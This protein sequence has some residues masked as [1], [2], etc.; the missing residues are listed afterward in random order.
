[1]TIQT[2]MDFFKRKSF[3]KNKEQ[4]LQYRNKGRSRYD[5]WKFPS[6]SVS[7]ALNKK[8]VISDLYNNTTNGWLIKGFMSTTEVEYALA[9]LK[10]LDIS[11]NGGFPKEA[12]HTNPRSFSMLADKETGVNEEL[13]DTY[14][15]DI[16]QYNA[17][18]Q[19]IFSFDYQERLLNFFS[20][21]EDNVD[22]QIPTIE[23]SGEKKQ[24]TT[25]TF[26]YCY[27][28]RGGMNTH[29][30]NMFPHIYP[31]FYSFLSKTMNIERQISYFVMLSKPEQGGDLVLY[32][33]LW[34][35]YVE[36]WDG[37]FTKANGEKALQADIDY[38]S[39]APEPGDMILFNGG[40]IWHKVD[41]LSGHTDRITVGGFLAKTQDNKI[42]VW[43]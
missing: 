14:F 35:Q 16:E 15:I 30:G 21:I 23:R 41:N 20:S 8:T 24:L 42:Y 17:V 22:V 40:D 12:G 18:L 9:N 31:L 36:W 6:I 28:N 11:A 27:P 1:M 34:G 19:N 33:A 3:V 5:L 37:Y 2:L 26:R 7:D 10:W 43:S 25:S 32:D 39:I 4:D 38:Q 29:V 13:L